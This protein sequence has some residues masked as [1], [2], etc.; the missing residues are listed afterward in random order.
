M[1]VSLTLAP[2]M[3][4]PL[5]SVTRPLSEV[6]ACA[7]AIPKSQS[8]PSRA[9]TGR[10]RVETEHRMQVRSLR[11]IWTSLGMA[12]QVLATVLVLYLARSVSTRCFSHGNTTCTIQWAQKSLPHLHLI[13]PFRRT[14]K[15]PQPE[16][17]HAFNP[18]RVHSHQ[19]GQAQAKT[20]V[21]LTTRQSARN[22]RLRSALCFFPAKAQNY[23]VSPLALES[24]KKSFGI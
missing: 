11:S 20:S 5:L 15:I 24:A 8:P 23:P 19:A 12:D 6:V 1:R 7:C 2:G 14:M 9:G 13:C 22:R 10:R 17:H 4:A 16:T 3:I 21:A 18:A